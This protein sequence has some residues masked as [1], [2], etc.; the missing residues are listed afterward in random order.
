M[1]KKRQLINIGV[2]LFGLSLLM[3][4]IMLLGHFGTNNN[5]VMAADERTTLP[6]IILIIVDTLRIN[7]VSTYGY[8]RPTTPHLDGRI[9]Q[10]GVRFEAHTSSPWT[11]P[12]NAA[13]MT[14]RIPSET[15]ASWETIGDT[16]PDSEKT[17]AEYLHEAGYYT[18]GF[19][20]RP[21]CIRG[22]LGFNQ[23]FDHYDDGLANNNTNGP[24]RAADLNL[25]V[26]DWLSASWTPVI[27]GSQPLF[28]FTYYFDP[29]TEYDP[30]PPYDIL[31][32]AA[33]TGTLTPAI[34]G[35][36]ETAKSGQLVLSARD[37]QYLNALYDGE[38]TYWDFYLGQ[39]LD[40]LESRHL[41]QN[42]LIIV[43]T[44]HGEMLGEHGEW[45]HAGSL[46]EEVVRVPMLM[47]YSGVISPG[48]AV[49]VPVQTM[50]LMPTILDYVGL[51]MPTNL[52][53]V[54]LRPFIEGSR[55]YTSSRPIYS[56]VDAVVDP[57]NPLFWASPPDDLRS[58]NLDGWKYIHHLNQPTASQ[59]YQLQTASIY[60]KN[61][62]IGQ[63]PEKHNQLRWHIM[64]TFLPHQLYLP[65]EMK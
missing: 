50:D 53:A 33:Y 17:L 25:L 43:T 63:E 38:I 49:T 52:Q 8:A 54:S 48:L 57:D 26:T 11:C 36:G 45:S 10:E 32:D 1:N 41:M 46:Y 62:L 55:P 47:R 30:P 34:F 5:N 9:A 14:G 28:L 7:H 6:N 3:V 19:T 27:S 20:S 16:L 23:G 44:D 24:V 65:V 15:G 40:E 61:N 31:Y 18:A 51:S 29:H 58:V 59:L 42:T 22:D 13:L 21:Y 2:I 39:L 12:S 56:E 60:E 4:T 64:D 35:H 37:L